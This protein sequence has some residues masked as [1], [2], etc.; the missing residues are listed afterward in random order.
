MPRRS[1]SASVSNRRQQHHNNGNGEFSALDYFDVAMTD[2]NR[3]A[4]FDK[5]EK[6]L[7]K[8]MYQRRDISPRRGG[9]YPPAQNSNTID[10]VHAAARNQLDMSRELE[11]RGHR[12]YQAGD[13][14]WFSQHPDVEAARRTEE[15]ARTYSAVEKAALNEHQYRLHRLHEMRVKQKEDTYGPGRGPRVQHQVRDQRH[16]FG[17]MWFGNVE[18]DPEAPHATK[19]QRTVATP[20]RSTTPTPSKSAVARSGFYDQPTVRAQQHSATTPPYDDGSMPPSPPPPPHHRSERI[21]HFATP[22]PGAS[23]HQH[24]HSPA[25]SLNN[26]TRHHHAASP[27]RLT[28]PSPYQPNTAPHHNY[29]PHLPQ[30]GPAMTPPMPYDSV[31]V[32][33][34]TAMPY[35]TGL[36]QA[37]EEGQLMHHA[38]LNFIL[39]DSEAY[40]EKKRRDQQMLR[41]AWEQQIREKKEQKLVKSA[42]GTWTEPERGWDGRAR[43][44]V[45]HHL[46]AYH[47]NDGI[48]NNGRSSAAAMELALFRAE[49]ARRVDEAAR[50]ACDRRIVERV[51]RRMGGTR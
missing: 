4:D 40:A 46:E 47:G 7:Q 38:R 25:H 45:S 12:S 44:I 24:H 50:R 51:E 18:S 13:N 21:L 37:Q 6:N 41:E 3:T 8:A 49:A 35:T 1:F 30:R 43:N 48:S 26:D 10:V 9:G 39:S 17:T 19:E 34:G 15:H 5:L 33:I 31:P 16:H 32:N 29:D 28:P 14:F 36:T 23:H 2:E 11:S 27:P 22:P 42:Q 20:R